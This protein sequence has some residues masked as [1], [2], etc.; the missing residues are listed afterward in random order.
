MSAQE[1]ISSKEVAEKKALEC[2]FAF[3]SE[4]VYA[5]V[6]EKTLLQVDD[7]VFY[8]KSNSEKKSDFFVSVPR[9]GKAPF[10]VH[11]E[12]YNLDSKVSSWY[13]KALTV[14]D[15]LNYGLTYPVRME[16][17]WPH[18]K[19]ILGY[20]LSNSSEVHILVQPYKGNIL[21]KLKSSFPFFTFYE[22][23]TFGDYLEKNFG[24]KLLSKGT[25]SIVSEPEYLLVLPFFMLDSFL[26][27]AEPEVETYNYFLTP[28]K[29]LENYLIENDVLSKNSPLSNSISSIYFNKKGK[30]LLPK[31]IARVNW[32]AGYEP[33]VYTIIENEFTSKGYM[34]F[35]IKDVNQFNELNKIL[36]NNIYVEQ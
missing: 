20:I 12:D 2:A 3:E 4:E 15:S 13:Y 19:E 25:S 7:W 14:S 9:D 30:L 16:E 10:L 17:I 23:T 31:S 24:A 27:K 33:R 34:E 32:F 21:P 22:K 5:L 29:E 18:S 1:E 6:P 8:F 35:F 11:P 28:T 26:G 36:G